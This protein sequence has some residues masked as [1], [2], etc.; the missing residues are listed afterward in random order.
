MKFMAGVKTP[1][2]YGHGSLAAEIT[3]WLVEWPSGV[4]EVYGWG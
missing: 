4:Y 1:V 2:V 3:A